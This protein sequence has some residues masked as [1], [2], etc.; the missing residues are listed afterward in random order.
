M[1]QVEGVDGVIVGMEDLTLSLGIPGDTRHPLVDEILEVII[2]ACQK[3]GISW[4]LHI[5]DVGR[6]QTWI[7]HEMQ[8][9]TYSSDIWMLQRLLRDDAAE[10]RQSIAG[11][12]L[13]LQEPSA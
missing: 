10:L 7:R 12:S 6:L 2:Q 9:V 8:L 11:S 1:L 13:T 4:G 3:N 5:P